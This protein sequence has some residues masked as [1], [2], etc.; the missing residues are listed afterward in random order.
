MDITPTSDISLTVMSLGHPVQL[1]SISYRQ[2]KRMELLLI[3]IQ[4]DATLHD[5]LIS[6]K[7]LYMFRVV[8]PPIIRSTHNCIY[9]IW[10]L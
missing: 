1:I 4:R 9:S 2:E 6:G 8:F 10:Y 5:S 3:Y 7:L